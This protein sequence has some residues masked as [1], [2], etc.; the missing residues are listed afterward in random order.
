MIIFL[1]WFQQ[2]SH[3]YLNFFQNLTSWEI[4]LLFECPFRPSI[5]EKSMLYSW[6]I[7]I[8]CIYLF[9]TTMFLKLTQISLEWPNSMLFCKNAL[10][11]GIFTAYLRKQKKHGKSKMYITEFRVLENGKIVALA[12]TVPQ[13][14]N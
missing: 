11:F 7:T 5:A 10:N 2:K 8:L 14:I 13:M 4:T 9:L 1:P 3:F 6:S 12:K